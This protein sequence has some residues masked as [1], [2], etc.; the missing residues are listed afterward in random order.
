MTG[1]I[2]WLGVVVLIGL[3]IICA[4][5]GYSM[6]DYQSVDAGPAPKTPPARRSTPRESEVYTEA[7]WLRSIGAQPERVYAGGEPVYEGRFA[8]GE[9]DYAIKHGLMKEG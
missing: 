6:D 4:A 2:I 9:R 7:D 5:I 8:R 3:L 1:L